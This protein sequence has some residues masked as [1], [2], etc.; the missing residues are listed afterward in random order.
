MGPPNTGLTVST[1][2]Q[3]GQAEG[4]AER[5]LLYF[6]LSYL[7][8][9]SLITISAER[10]RHSETLCENLNL[11]RY[12]CWEKAGGF[13][14][15]AQVHL[16]THLFQICPACEEMNYFF[17]S[18]CVH[19]MWCGRGE[20]KL[21]WFKVQ[22]F[23]MLPSLLLSFPQIGSPFH[24]PALNLSS[25]GHQLREHTCFVWWINEFKWS[26]YTAEM[27]GKENLCQCETCVCLYRGWDIWFINQWQGG[28]ERC[29]G[30]VTTVRF[31]WCILFFFILSLPRSYFW[32]ACFLSGAGQSLKH[33]E[34]QCVLILCGL[35]FLV[36]LWAHKPF[37]DLQSTRLGKQKQ[38]AKAVWE[39]CLACPSGQ[40]ETWS[41]LM[42]QWVGHE[43]I[44][45]L[46]IC[47]ASISSKDTGICCRGG[48][49]IYCS[50]CINCLFNKDSDWIC[51][52]SRDQTE[53]SHCSETCSPGSSWLGQPAPG[54]GVWVQ[55]I[56]LELSLWLAESPLPW[57]DFM[58]AV[59]DV[60]VEESPKPGCW[61]CLWNKAKEQRAGLGQR[62][63]RWKETCPFCQKTAIPS[64]ILGMPP[65]LPL[66]YL[67]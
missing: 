45:K 40:V 41:V 34:G 22:P 23:H 4:E 10:L 57:C 53:F 18:N 1:C 58:L 48:C 36:M 13:P 61:A 33:P 64:A 56:A 67:H 11:Y 12:L 2:L 38:A 9:L 32:L 26:L 54:D 44:K 27:C 8:D 15:Q 28:K 62:E 7:V 25:V 66:G 31:K 51:S 30:L 46:L 6:S 16:G 35:W 63:Y 19:T 37:Q 52:I 17:H 39:L 14:P 24:S 43:E 50:A 65:F 59:A 47:A 5:N 55:K 60:D 3:W 49:R 42:L 29:V 21:C 20:G